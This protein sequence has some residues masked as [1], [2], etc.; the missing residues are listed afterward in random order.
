MSNYS[1]EL[2][3]AKEA[4]SE[5]A[6]IIREYDRKRSELNIQLKGKNDLVTDADLASEQK[7]I[8]VI[9]N[10]FPDDE[11]LAEESE[12]QQ[13]LPEGRV[14]IIDP[15][16]GTTN[17]AHGFPVY[18]VSIA[19][20]E[21][22]APKVGL[23]LEVKHGELYTAIAGEGAWLDGEPIQV[24][25]LEDPEASLLGTGFPYDDFSLVKEYLDLFDYF[26]KHTHG[27]RRP[28][29]AAYDL[30]TVACG[31]LDGFFEYSLHAWDVAAAV[32]IIT[33]AGGKVTDWEGGD[34]WLFG[35]RIITANET[36]HRFI[37][38]KIQR[39]I[40][41]DNRKAK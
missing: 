4:A 10:S 6:E 37:F 14:W 36:I 28:G 3:V 32:L 34:Q 35:E 27:V 25:S 20:W 13:H 38:D 29:S 40:S 8:E 18:C 31:R 24:S 7:I 21:G 41:A 39:Y 26:M 9:R 5:A 23:V 16:D 22:G 30:C 12:E 17:F 11:F 1:K 2:Q 33:E 15:I 19:L